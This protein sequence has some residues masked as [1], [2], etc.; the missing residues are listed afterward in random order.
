MPGMLAPGMVAAVVTYLEMTDPPPPPPAPAMAPLKLV[1]LEKPDLQ[2]YRALFRA[3]GGPWL[4]FSRLVMADDALAAIIHDPLVEVHTVSSRSG[5]DLGL[6]ELDFRKHGECELSFFGLVPEMTGRGHGK[7][8]M[9]RAI[10]RAWREGVNRFR[11]HTCTLDH[12]AALAFYRRQG[13]RPYARGVERFADPRI[14]GI[15]PE[16]AAPHVPLIR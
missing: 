3:V 1:R 9:Q 8:L 10:A 16:N 11:V 7:W 14:A 6:L 5:A 13:F 15:L 2:R 4:W 12:P